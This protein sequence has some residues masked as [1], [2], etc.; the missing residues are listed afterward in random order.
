MWKSV[1]SVI[2]ALCFTIGV[3]GLGWDFLLMYELR[4][5]FV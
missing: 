5:P 2:A 3:V 4:L 1:L